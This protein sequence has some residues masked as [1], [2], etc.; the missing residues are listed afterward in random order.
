MLA[1][2]GVETSFGFANVAERSPRMRGSSRDDAVPEVLRGDLAVT[3]GAIEFPGR[4]VVQPRGCL[5]SLA[6]S[7]GQ[8]LGVFSSRPSTE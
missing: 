3:R 6:H 8:S 1:R 4:F 7:W 2:L 5:Q